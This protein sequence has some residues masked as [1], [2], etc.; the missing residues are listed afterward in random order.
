[1]AQVLV[2]AAC[3]YILLAPSD[4]Q[5][6]AEAASLYDQLTR[7]NWANPDEVITYE[8]DD[9]GSLTKKH[10]G[11][12]NAPFDEY[13]YNLENRL[14]TFDPN[15]G[16]TVTYKYNDDGIRVEK[17]VA[18]TTT[19]YLIDPYNHTGYAQVLEEWDT[20]STPTLI[21][22]YTIGDDVITQAT[23]TSI[24]HLL[25]DGH[26]STRQTVNNSEAVTDAFSYDAYGV[27]LGNPASTTTNLLYTGEMYDS[28]SDSYYLR[29]RYYF[30]STGTFNRPDPF[31]GN[32]QDPQS[33]HKYVYAHSNPVNNVD[34]SGK[35]TLTE[36]LV[37]MMIVGVVFAAYG[38]AVVAV[39]GGTLR[40]V[41]DAQVRW[42]W[43]GVILGGVAYAGIWATTAVLTALYGASAGFG[44][45]QYA[46]EYGIC[47]YRVLKSQIQGTG[48]QAHHIIPGRFDTLL[49]VSYDDMLC[50]AVDPALEHPIFTEAWRS[51]I[52]HEAGTASATKGLIWFHAQRIY[53]NCPALLDAAKA[54]LL[55]AGA[56]L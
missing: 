48:L 49:K 6:T 54:Q 38:G 39:R 22:T 13:V 26:G 46:K 32:N 56:S 12:I 11:D 45:L 29:A 20:T 27:L 43:L 52:S 33:L 35:F 50:V 28:Q 10:Y 24:E 1:M 21:K 15:S 37:T 40:Q 9:N 41:V 55:N 17:T 51:A 16:D 7:A 31:Q 34:P 4:L 23:S 25:Y 44:D 47:S 36:M 42:F 8:Y 14:A 5:R 3:L 30:P 53:E 2:G 18:G 19:K